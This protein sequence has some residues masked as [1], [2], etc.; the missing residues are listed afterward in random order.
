M[1]VNF[2][3][4][5]REHARRVDDRVVVSSNFR[6]CSDSSELGRRCRFRIIAANGA[7]VA[8]GAACESKAAAKHAVTLVQLHAGGAKTVDSTQNPVL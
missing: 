3:L 6:V 7:I 1:R 5:A 8:V 4:A 2:G